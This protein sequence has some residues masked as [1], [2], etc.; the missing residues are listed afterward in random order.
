E[1]A[2]GPGDVIAMRP[3]GRVHELVWSVGVRGRLPYRPV[4]VVGF[5]AIAG[6]AL[7]PPGSPSGRLWV[8]DW[9][10]RRLSIPPLPRCAPDWS[11]GGAHLYCLRAAA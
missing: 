11:Q 2:T 6:I 7:G 1:Q 4:S 5:G 8:L 3:A 10:S 9:T